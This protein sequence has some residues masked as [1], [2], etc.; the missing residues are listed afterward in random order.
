[1]TT[2]AELF[3]DLGPAL[4]RAVR[5]AAPDRSRLV[6]Q[7]VVDAV[8]SV[9]DIDLG[10]LA[11]DAWGKYAEL[12]QAAHRTSQPGAAPERVRLAEHTI[13]SVHEPTVETYVNGARVLTVTLGLEIE[14]DVHVLDAE[15]ASG[16]LCG[17][18]AGDVDVR[19]RLSI[20]GRPVAERGRTFALGAL[21]AIERPIPLVAQAPDP[22]PRHDRPRSSWWPR[23][24]L[25]VAVLIAAFSLGGLVTQSVDWAEALPFQPGTVAEVRAGS[26]W[27][28][29]NG[30]ARRSDPVGTVVPGQR[31]RVECLAGEWAKLLTPCPG[32]YVYASGLALGSVPPPCAR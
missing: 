19:A 6:R 17:I 2:V 24:V 3:G 20:D 15:I 9:L 22:G 14:L 11:L 23:V 26:E 25:T 7:P 8:G 16:L 4:D 21:I 28:V 18:H 29:R 32:R 5:G 27:F 13:T 12:R 10:S 30:P 31:V 1:M